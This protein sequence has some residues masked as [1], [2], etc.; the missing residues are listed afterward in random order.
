MESAADKLI[1]LV[2]DNK[3][4]RDLT[5]LAFEEADIANPVRV[6]EDGQEAL[7]YLFGEGKYQGSEPNPMPHLMLLD[8][9]LPKIDGLEVLKRV[10]GHRRTRL[11]PVII[12]TSSRERRDLIGGYSHRANSY[13]RKP[14]NFTEFVDAARQL[15]LYWLRLNQHPRHH[16]H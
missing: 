7:D 15:D 12:L 16:G 6:C 10:R 4:D 14:V 13:I 2:E 11:L 9:N 1:L 5:L 8:L 3:D